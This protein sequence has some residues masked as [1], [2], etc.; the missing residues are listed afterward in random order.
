MSSHRIPSGRHPGQTPRLWGLFFAFS[1]GLFATWHVVATVLYL[2]PQ[3]PL[4]K[5]YDNVVRLYMSPLFDQNWHLFSPNPITRT[6]RIIVRCE[7]DAGQKSGWI[8]PSN[9]ALERHTKLLGVTGRSYVLRTYLGLAREISEEIE[10]RAMKCGQDSS[11]VEKVPAGLIEEPRFAHVNRYATEACHGWSNETVRAE[12]QLASLGAQ[13]YS[14]RAQAWSPSVA[15]TSVGSIQ[16]Q[17]QH[18]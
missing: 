5:H 16:V 14:K 7:T 10:R 12:I 2:V 18:R 15:R 3:N 9:A 17:R 11:C 13:P 4:S 1:I 8:E 6:E